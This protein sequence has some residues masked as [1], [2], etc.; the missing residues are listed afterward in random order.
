MSPDV[1][2]TCETGGGGVGVPCEA[3]PSR[4]RD[5]LVN[6]VLT[7]PP[8]V[9]SFGILD[10]PEVTDCCLSCDPGPVLGKDFSLIVVEFSVNDLVYGGCWSREPCARG[11]D[12][13]ELLV[14]GKFPYELGR[15]SRPV[16]N[17]NEQSGL[18]HVEWVEDIPLG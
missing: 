8:E 11:R 4:A 5:W 2:P 7:L 13:A 10:F 17:P 3:R 9:F 6:A 12:P 18:L 1:R 14:A 16:A 15:V